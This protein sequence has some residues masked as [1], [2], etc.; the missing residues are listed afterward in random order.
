MTHNNSLRYFEPYIGIPYREPPDINGEGLHCWELVEK[1]MQEVFGVTPPIV[2][3]TGSIKDVEPVFMT[4]LAAWLFVCN[5]QQLPG[6]LVLIRM[7]GYPVHCG[8]LVSPKVMLHTL[9]GRCSCIEN[10]TRPQWKRRVLGFYRWQN[11]R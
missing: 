3:Y 7:A 10:I 6:D 2:H 5:G 1:V 4:Q 8:I 11:E 9:K